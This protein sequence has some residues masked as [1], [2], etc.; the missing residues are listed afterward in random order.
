[1]QTTATVE[2]TGKQIKAVYLLAET[3]EC[4]VLLI[5]TEAKTPEVLGF[6]GVTLVMKDAKIRLHN[7]PFDEPSM[8]FMPDR[9]CIHV[10]VYTSKLEHALS[11]ENKGKTLFDIDPQ[12]W[13]RTPTA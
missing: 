13:Q 1:M 8:I 9:H 10:C 7:L 11:F 6:N 12:P 4:V 5:N 2:Q 3:P